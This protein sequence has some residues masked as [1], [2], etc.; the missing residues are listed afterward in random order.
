MAV[1]P[2]LLT[3]VGTK[4]NIWLLLYENCNM[5]RV[6]AGETAHVTKIIKIRPGESIA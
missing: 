6:R 2:Q 3:N 4:K 5:S 1:L